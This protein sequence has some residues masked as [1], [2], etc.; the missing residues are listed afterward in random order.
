M[1]D[2]QPIILSRAHYRDLRN[3]S[4]DLAVLP[5]GA[6]EA[7]NLHLPYGTDVIES[8]R[9]AADAARIASDR[10]ARIIVLPALPYGVNPLQLD[11]PLTIHMNPSTQLAIV[12]DIVSSL[13]AH[14]IGKLVILNSHGGNDF[15]TIIRELQPKTKVFLSTLNWWQSLKASEFF[16]E[17]GDHAGELETA[18]ML[19]ICPDQVLPLSEAG[20]GA[21]KQS[22]ISGFREGWA[23]APRPW[24]VVTADTGIGNPSAATAERGARYYAAMTGKVATFLADLAAATPE[25]LYA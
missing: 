11:I 12:R 19:H 4:Y 21:A 3:A 16:W 15:K 20:S 1:A 9:I 14:R 8:E 23:W 2:E 24:S 17:P 6:T 13:E 18:V 10:G 25:S 5:W 22:T 7:H